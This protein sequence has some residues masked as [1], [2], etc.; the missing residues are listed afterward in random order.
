[1]IFNSYQFMFFFPIFL[2]LYY[3]IPKKIRLIY[4]LL[5]S[6]YFYMANTWQHAIILVFT[7]IVSYTA[8][9]ILSRIDNQ[10]VKKSVLWGTVIVLVGVLG[11]YKFSQ[12][13][14][15]LGLS[16]SVIYFV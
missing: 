3:I 2:I 9:I 6:Y 15:P 11:T 5:A 13:S 10:R 12:T 8:G 14:L 4:L 7:T 1:M 16:E